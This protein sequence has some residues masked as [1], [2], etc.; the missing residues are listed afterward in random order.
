MAVGVAIMSQFLVGYNTGVMNAPEAVVFP[1]HTT[2]EWSFA[3]SAFAIGGPL[4]SII[5]GILANRW[6]RRGAMMVCIHMHIFV[7]WFLYNK[8]SQLMFMCRQ[9]CGYFFLGV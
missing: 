8:M 4:G 2:L 5:G 7:Q 1:G 6:G 9:M 3:V